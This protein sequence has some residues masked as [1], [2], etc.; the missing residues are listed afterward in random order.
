[1]AVHAGEV[2]ERE[3]DF[4]GPVINRCATLRGLR[5]QFPPL[6]SL[7]A[8]PNNLPMQLT[9]FVGRERELAGPRQQLVSSPL[10]TLVGIG[11]C[12]KTRLALQT[13]AD[14]VER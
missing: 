9:S 2:Q 8:Q 3:A 5:E 4:H 14:A 10:V 11:G 12:G 6:N 1:M 7:E 13:A